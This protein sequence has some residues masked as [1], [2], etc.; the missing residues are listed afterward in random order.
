MERRVEI[1]IYGHVQGVLFRYFVAKNAQ[2]LG[3][4]GL[5]RNADDGTVNIIA[6][7]EEE[8]LFL[9]IEQ[10]EEGPRLAEVK[11]VGVSWS[12]KTG[13]FQNFDIQ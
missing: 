2:K 4:K 1:R 7:G 3:I 9:L 5:V 12:P 10:C 6:E 13:E 8:K 11:K